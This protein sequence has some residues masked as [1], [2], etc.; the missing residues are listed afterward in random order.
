MSERPV[1]LV[2]DDDPP[3]LLLMKSVLQEFGFEPVPAAHGGDAL[4]R[5]RARRPNLILLDRNMPGMNGDDVLRELRADERLS[6]V[7]VIILSGSPIEPGELAAI[8]ANAAVMKPFDLP[9]LI[10]AIRQHLG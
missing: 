10:D 3:I 4:E 9:A 7:P 5:A 6:S 8:G 2:V 1:I